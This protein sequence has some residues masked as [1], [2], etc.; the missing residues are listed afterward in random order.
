MRLSSD[1]CDRAVVAFA[2]RR[3]DRTQTSQRS[4]DNH[5]PPWPLT[6]VWEKR[7]GYPFSEAPFVTEGAHQGLVGDEPAGSRG[8]IEYVELC[9]DP[10]P[11]GH[12]L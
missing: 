3:L 10:F 6:I 4:P 8:R 12:G 1:E 9:G 11:S 5:E 7:L 2:P